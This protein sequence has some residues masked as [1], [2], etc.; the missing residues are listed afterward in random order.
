M[1]HMGAGAERAGNRLPLY[2]T[3]ATLGAAGL[4]LLVPSWREVLFTSCGYLLSLDMPA[5]RDYLRSFGSQAW[6]ISS[7]LMIAQALAA[8]ISAVPITLANALIFGVWGGVLISWSSAQVAAL[9]CFFLA[10]SLGRPFV[11]RL[12]STHQIRRWDAFFERYGVLAILV[13][14]LIPVVSFDLV[15]Y[16]AGITRVRPLPFALATGLGQLPAAIVY[17]Y[18]GAELASSPTH[19]VLTML[20]FVGGTVLIVGV[21]WLR[22]RRSPHA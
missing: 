13:A 20:W 21:I 19:A 2:V 5:L 7:S 10:R 18:A 1:I 17:S 11:E 22:M 14:R 3:L 15:S 9:I 16:A 6:I 4:V 8:P 12:F